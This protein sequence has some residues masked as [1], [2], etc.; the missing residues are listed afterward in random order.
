M[1]YQ[2]TESSVKADSILALM[3]E[4]ARGEYAEKLAAPKESEKPVQKT[5]EF[6]VFCAQDP[7]LRDLNKQFLDAKAYHQKLIQENGQDDPMAEIAADMED[8]AWCA[9]QTRLLELKKEPERVRQVQRIVLESEIAYQECQE[10]LAQKKMKDSM[11]FF[12]N[13]L[14]FQDQ[15][16]QAR[17]DSGLVFF[18][19]A[20]IFLSLSAKRFT[21]NVYIAKLV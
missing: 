13:M 8:S 10:R 14:R 21:P 12:M 11:R 15:K 4:M 19:I 18:V 7:L 2:N 16:R 3:N 5:T 9:V 6:E 17:A 1:G 20:M